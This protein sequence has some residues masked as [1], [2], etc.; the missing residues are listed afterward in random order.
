MD[1]IKYEDDDFGMSTACAVAN[2]M[3]YDLEVPPAKAMDILTGILQEWPDIYASGDQHRGDAV[4]F[5]ELKGLV[6]R[7][8]MN[9]LILIICVLMCGGLEVEATTINGVD[10]NTINNTHN[11]IRRDA[12]FSDNYPDVIQTAKDLIKVVKTEYDYIH[13]ITTEF[14]TVIYEATHHPFQTAIKTKIGTILLI[15]VSLALIVGFS[16]FA[17]LFFFYVL[18]PFCNIVVKITIPIFKFLISLIKHMKCTM[19]CCASFPFVTIR[20]KYYKFQLNRKHNKLIQVVG[21]DD[22]V[23]FI[24]E[25]S[26]KSDL[27]SDENGVY[28]KDSINNRK[29]YINTAPPTVLDMFKLSGL[30]SAPAIQHESN[31]KESLLP[32]SEIYYLDKVPP[33]VGTF[34]VGNASHSTVIGMFSRILYKN[35]HCILT[36][37]HVLESGKGLDLELCNKDIRIKANSIPDVSIE[38]YSAP[39]QLDFAIL[40]VPEVLFSKLQLKI[41]KITSRITAGTPVKI[42][43]YRNSEQKFGFSSGAITGYLKPYHVAYKVSTLRGSSGSPILNIKN[44]IMGV[45]IE[46]DLENQVNVGVVPPIFRSKESDMYEDLLQ[47][48]S[49]YLQSDNEEDDKYEYIEFAIRKAGN[50]DTDKETELREKGVTNWAQIMD[51][52]DRDDNDHLQKYNA[53]LY[54]QDDSGQHRQAMVKQ[55]VRRKYDIYKESPLIC[56]TCRLIF[57]EGY[58][59]PQCKRPLVKDNK[60]DLETIRVVEE[61][62]LP[63]T[64]IDKIQINLIKDVCSQIIRDSL[65]NDNCRKYF[66]EDLELL[67]NK[68]SQLEIKVSSHLVDKIYP[69][70]NTKP[71]SNEQFLNKLEKNEK[72]RSYIIK[73]DTDNSERLNLVRPKVNGD[74]TVINDGFNIAAIELPVKKS[75]R[76]KW[77]S[78]D[79]V[80]VNV[81]LTNDYITDRAAALKHKK[82]LLKIKKA[83]EKKIERPDTYDINYEDH[84]DTIEYNKASLKD[85]EKQIKFVYDAIGKGEFKSVLNQ[86]ESLN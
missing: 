80:K 71:E 35:K 38:A 77:D 42:L 27:H 74:L 56:P 86:K 2:Q 10:S 61:L 70:L 40:S 21:K 37:A 22:L 23:P 45:H 59:C 46:T 55:G 48:S 1:N 75:Y 78:E 84:Q 54:H 63:Q 83:L 57:Q 68:I 17:R 79:K 66:K 73:E 13:N 34:N 11:I 62:P 47:Q 3:M 58:K 15:F 16:W 20:D 69:V 5:D 41:G 39:D 49:Y 36:A 18:K 53:K 85:I 82:S 26:V 29:I 6:R 72:L 9:A 30:P 67:A 51:E 44:E 7:L 65:S 64:A 25:T 4:R 50:F 8:C 33:F 14:T 24:L 19:F 52:I 81:K 28:V 32:L 60:P 12:Q 43:S 31:F 76:P